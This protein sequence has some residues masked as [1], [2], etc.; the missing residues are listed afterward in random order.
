MRSRIE[1][2]TLWCVIG[3]ILVFGQV[4]TAGFAVVD[5]GPVVAGRSGGAT[6][7]NASGAASGFT[8]GS[9]GASQAVSTDGSSAFQA[10]DTSRLPGAASSVAN[11]IN[12]SG[13]LAG[14]FYSASD[15]TFHAFKTT[16][17]QAIDLGT[18]TSGSF[19][20]ADTFGVG[21][22]GSGEVVGTARL[23]GGTQVV[24]RS[25][26]PGQV[27]T[28]LLPG[29]SSVG[30][31]AGVNES[32]T[33]VGTYL[34]AQGVARVFTAIGNQAIDLLAQYPTQ[35]FGLNSS[36]GAINNQGSVVGS[37]DFGGQS[38][39]FIAATDQTTG[40]K[41]LID[42]GVIGGFGSSRAVGINDNN[43]VVGSLDNQGKSSH[44]FLWDQS[45]GLLDLN[46]LLAP[47]DQK[48][49]TLTSASGINNSGQIV[50]Q[51][52]FNG[53][54]HGFLLNPIPG[55]FPFLTPGLAPAPPSL[56]MALGAMSMVGIWLRFKPERTADLDAA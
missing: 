21:I 14:T 30:Q 41:S 25:S 44:A 52:L 19:R 33:I 39:A 6:G 48:V 17:G 54:S 34:N 55:T 45:F 37:G 35:G 1:R 40:V 47:A 43:Q 7:I 38:H 36:G 49:W 22:S 9:S 3:L 42:I 2:P 4:A 16:A 29:N 15:K 50:G 26:I 13:D 8:T 27:S 24:F 10:V 11:A 12:S 28:I 56:W 31:A 18:F 20:G 5:L 32:G 53:Q 51:G 46:S 23:G